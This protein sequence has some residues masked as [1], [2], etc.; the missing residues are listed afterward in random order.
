V[1]SK[2]PNAPWDFDA[3]A[4]VAVGFGK[5]LAKHLRN[6]IYDMRKRKDI[7]LSHVLAESDVVALDEEEIV[8]MVGGMVEVCHCPAG[9]RWG[10]LRGGGD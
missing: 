4:S 3:W 5:L 7:P 8:S 2:T 9:T 6:N 10:R 1:L